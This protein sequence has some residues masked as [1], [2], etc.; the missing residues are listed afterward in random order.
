MVCSSGERDEITFVSS[1]PMS[2]SIFPISIMLTFPVFLE[3]TS[4]SSWGSP[5]IFFSRDYACGPSMKLLS[6]LVLINQDGSV[7]NMWSCRFA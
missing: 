6:R 5:R 4:S 3:D 2:S 1:V 7:E